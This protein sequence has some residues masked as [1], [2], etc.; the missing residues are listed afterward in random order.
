[1]SSI[2]SKRRNL[3]SKQTELKRIQDMISSYKS[4]EEKLSK[5][6]ESLKDDIEQASSGGKIFQIPDVTKI[7]KTI[8]QYGG[9]PR[10]GW[11]RA[12]GVEKNNE[13]TFKVVEGFNPDVGGLY[14]WPSNYIVRYGTS[15]TGII[16]EISD[17]L[18]TLR[19]NDVKINA[20][21]YPGINDVYVPIEALEH[22]DENKRG[23]NQY[24]SSF[25]KGY[26]RKQKH[27]TTEDFNQKIL[28][29]RDD[30]IFSKV[31]MM[32]VGETYDIVLKNGDKINNGKV[33]NADTVGDISIEG[34]SRDINADQIQTITKIDKVLMFRP[35]KFK[36][37]RSSKKSMKRKVKRSAKKSTKR[38]VKRSAKKVKRSAKK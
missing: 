8:T 35:F 14:G 28:S 33:L 20:K 32:E 37:K 38:K 9:D 13:Y 10:S 30:D 3:Q 6:I 25:N 18:T 24:G 16:I 22:V 12:Y 19:L 31:S 2:E 17:D 7:D 29:V 34:R 23:I 15:I 5:E 21:E 36:V 1:M 27:F 26:Q 11:D 4:Q